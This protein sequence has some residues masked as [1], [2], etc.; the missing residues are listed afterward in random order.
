VALCLIALSDISSVIIIVSTSE[1]GLHSSIVSMSKS[2]LYQDWRS[3]G[4]SA[5]VSDTHLGPATNFP[6]L[7]LIIFRRL[8]VCWCGAPSLTRSRV[9]IFQLLLGIA[10][11]AFLR[12]ESHE[13]HEH[14]L[15]SLFLRL[16]QPEEPG[17]CTYFPQE[18]GSPVITP[19][20]GLVCYFSNVTQSHAS[21]LSQQSWCN[22]ESTR[23]SYCHWWSWR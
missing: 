2:K 11:A 15:L 20:I 22:V 7:S 21:Y 9:C 17:S 12:Y 23:V 4:Q 16:P 18:H 1:M 14:I 10:S 13:T 5:L 19:G 6:L 8:R 3:V